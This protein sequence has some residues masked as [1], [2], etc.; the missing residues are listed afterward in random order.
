MAFRGTYEYTIDDRGRLPIPARYRNVFASGLVLVEAD[1][2]CVELYT[3]EGYDEWA[4]FITR[5]P[6]H[7]RKS[8]RLRRGFFGRSMD[9]EMDRQGRVLLPPRLRQHGDL[10]GAVIVVGRGEC[11]EVWN[12]ARWE[13][14]G[15]L[16]KDEYGAALESLE[17]RP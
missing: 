14:E 17:E 1:D 13:A 3:V 12:P 7:R 9:A 15:A 10:N 6:A 5:Q 2:G 4:E 8:R 16:V 11:L